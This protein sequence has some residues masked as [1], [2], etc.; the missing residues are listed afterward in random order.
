MVESLKLFD[1]VCNNPWFANTSMILFLNKKDLFEQKIKVT[2]L[3]VV[4]P[5]YTGGKDYEKALTYIRE[6]FLALNQNPKKHIYVHPTCAT[7][8]QN[9]A[10][11]FNAVKDIILHKL[12]DQSG[13]GF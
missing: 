7:D 13:I 3:T 12:L 1:S 8:T 2:D 11:V 5:E 6:K 10:V 9:I 4:F